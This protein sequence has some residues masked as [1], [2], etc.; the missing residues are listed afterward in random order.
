MSQTLV[1]WSVFLH[2]WVKCLDASLYLSSASVSSDFMALYKCCYYYYYYYYYYK[3]GHQ[4]D[5]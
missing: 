4:P 5:C 2:C 3:T 1:S